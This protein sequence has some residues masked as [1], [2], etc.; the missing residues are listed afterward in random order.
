MRTDPGAGQ[1]TLRTE[2]QH[3]KRQQAHSVEIQQEKGSQL[4]LV[5]NIERSPQMN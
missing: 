3:R 4:G 2:P 1:P 5:L